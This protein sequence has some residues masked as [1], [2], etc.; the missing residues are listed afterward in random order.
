MTHGGEWR[1]ML[2]GP[3]AGDAHMAR[4]VRLARESV[5]TVRFFEWRPAAVSL[6][7][8]QAR[9]EWLPSAGA[10]WVE[11][12]TG[13]GI[14]LHGTDLSLSVVV[15]RGLALPL[16]TLMQAVCRSAAKLCESFG[17]SA[18]VR[19]DAP[20]SGRITYCLAEES[21]YAVLIGGRKVAGF[22][23]RRYPESWLVQGS[24]LIRPVD[25][26]VA[27]WLP[28]AA[29]EALLARA[30]ALADEAAIAVTEAVAAERWAEQWSGWWDAA[31]LDALG[32]PA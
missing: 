13:G 4:D 26:A 22:A 19:L 6:G 11:R 5:P 1:M 31:L 27:G 23:V 2:D 9:P 25:A 7:W 29:R 15:P 16:D 24:L 8:K 21:P 30:V 28:Q 17:A 14:A 20:G 18:E 3:G 12:P 10:A 32:V